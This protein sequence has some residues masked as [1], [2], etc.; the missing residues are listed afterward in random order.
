MEDVLTKEIIDNEICLIKLNRPKALN[1]L[2]RNLVET[3]IS[4][5]D[6]CESNNDIRSIILTGNGRGFCAGADLMDGGWPHEEGWSAGKATANAMD[7]GFNPL[8][9]KIVNSKK[10][11][12]NAINGVTA[13]GGVGLALC[14]DIVIASKSAIFKLVFGPQLGIIPD[15]GASWLVPNLI[16]R[17]K[18]NGL[19]LLGDDLDAKTAFEWGL[20]WK[21]VDDD[22]LINEAT[23]IAK[24]VSDSA[25]SG[26]KAVVKAHDNALVSTLDE[27]LEYER[28]TQEV[29]CNK[30]EFREGVRAFREKRKPNF[31]DIDAN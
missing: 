13:G 19:A 22:N 17:A 29:F 24:K 31:R 27:Q 12:I 9:R 6:E 26:L 10:P 28:D 16:G 8:V 5:I 30:E 18:A 23:K 7:I 3:I 20:I 21:V 4:S 14:G 11:I 15:V 25:I 1:S 2:N